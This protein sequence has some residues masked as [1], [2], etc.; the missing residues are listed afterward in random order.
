LK[1][2]FI[3]PD[4]ELKLS[5]HSLLVE[6]PDQRIVVDTCV[7]TSK[8]RNAPDWNLLQTSYLQDLVMHGWTRESVSGVLCTHL[9]VDHVGWNTLLIDGRW[10]PTFPNARYYFARREFKY[11][12]GESAVYQSKLPAHAADMMDFSS[13]LADSV[14]PVIDANLVQ[15]ID[16]ETQITPEIQLIPTPGHSPGH[17]SV[18]ITSQGARAV[19]TGDIAHHPM[20]IANPHWSSFLDTDRAQATRTRRYIFEKFANT[21]T[22]IIGT[23]F[24]GRTAG[25]LVREGSAYRF[26]V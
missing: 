18:L 15:L 10:V 17:V 1:P 4:N 5:I 12:Q 25:H 21:P 20:Q 14:Q 16:P 11:W 3:T 8:L 19:I 13:V 23:H 22:L 9:H 7:G 6:T 2:D 24:A 26:E